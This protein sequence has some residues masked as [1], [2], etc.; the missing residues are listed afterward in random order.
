MILTIELSLMM[1]AKIRMSGGEWLLALRCLWL[2]AAMGFVHLASP[3]LE[4][5]EFETVMLKDGQRVVG[6]IVAERTAAIYVD[7]GYDILRIPRDQVL[8][9]VK[10]AEAA[11]GPRASAR[12][13]E[14]D[15]SGFYTSGMLKPSP[16]KELVSK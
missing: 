11:A 4:A 10:G 2:I 5:G 1:K 12:S 9:R 6:E 7:L 16:I 3:M 14:E 15:A 8:R 13:T